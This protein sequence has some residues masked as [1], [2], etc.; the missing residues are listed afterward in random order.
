EQPD[1]IVVTGDFFDGHGQTGVVPDST[2]L[3]AGL[4]APDGVFGC[5]GN[6]DIALDARGV[7]KELTRSPIDLLLNDH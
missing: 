7:L 5:L 6:H 1:L 3:F 4:T 2:D